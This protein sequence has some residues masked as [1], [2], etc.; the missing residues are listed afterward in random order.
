MKTYA[1]LLSFLVLSGSAVAQERA[2]N[3]A[4][5]D[6]PRAYALFTSEGEPVAWPE[7]VEAASKADVV[8]FGELHDDAIMHWLQAELVRDLIGAGLAPALGAEMLEAD[9]QLVVNEFL[10]GLVNEDKLKAAANLWPNHFTDYQ[11]LLNLAQEHG[12]PFIATNVPRRYASYV[13]KNGLE[14]LSDLSEDA[15]RYLPP[16]PV[17]FDLN[18]PGYQA[19]MAMGGGHGGET[20]PMAQAIKDAT[21]AHF[22]ATNL[23]LKAPFIHFNGAYHSQDREGIV[24]Y[25]KQ[26]LPKLRI[27]TLH[28]HA[29]LDVAVPNEEALGR[30]DFLLITNELVTRTH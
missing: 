3:K 25:L 20:L 8:L 2:L 22:I 19:M 13:Y 1:F 14:A 29:Q 18:L 7:L 12:L 4:L 27:L 10:A 9:D 21:M 26:E 28:G 30:G 11:P 16:L 6:S 24:W 17:A 23:P 15:K 5:A